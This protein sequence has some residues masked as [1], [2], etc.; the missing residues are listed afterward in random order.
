MMNGSASD[1]VAA[2]HFRGFLPL[3]ANEIRGY[4]FLNRS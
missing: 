3:T 1:V 2:K 4:K